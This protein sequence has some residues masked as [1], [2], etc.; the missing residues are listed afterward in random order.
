MYVCICISRNISIKNK[1]FFLL[2]VLWFVFQVWFCWVFLI[3]SIK[4]IILYEAVL[5]IKEYRRFIKKM[6]ESTIFRLFRTFSLRKWNQ[7]QMFLRSVPY[8]PFLQKE[9]RGWGGG[10]EKKKGVLSKLLLCFGISESRFQTQSK[11]ICGIV[12]WKATARIF[13]SPDMWR[14][15]GLV[16]LGILWSRS[17]MQQQCLYIVQCTLYTAQ[18]TPT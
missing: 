17:I 12:F 7:M 3:L 1:I 4:I 16:V 2:E 9:R 10:G 14:G 6:R 13:G 18:Q 5:S 15:T 11:H 8:L